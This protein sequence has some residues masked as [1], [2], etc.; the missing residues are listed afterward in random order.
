MDSHENTRLREANLTEIRVGLVRPAI[1]GCCKSCPKDESS[2]GEYETGSSSISVDH[3]PS[4]AENRLQVASRRISLLRHVIP[5]FD[6][7]QFYYCSGY[8][9]IVFRATRYRN[10]WDVY[11]RL[12]SCACIE[13]RF[14][15]WMEQRVGALI[16]VCA[17]IHRME[18][19]R[20]FGVG[21]VHW[22]AVV[23]AVQI[24]RLISR[25]SK[26]FVGWPV[27]RSSDGCDYVGG[28]VLESFI[29]AKC[30]VHWA[31][32]NNYCVLPLQTLIILQL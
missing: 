11:S 4:H 28:C 14:L 24:S 10:L 2:H 8:V 26:P 9:R 7:L 23:R 31:P 25:D 29:A 32:A 22:H 1:T 20:W 5:A 21:E 15:M 19:R 18:L 27:H 12:N 30:K 16:V 3:H 13:T 17:V 6:L